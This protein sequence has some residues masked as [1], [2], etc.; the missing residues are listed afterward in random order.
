MLAQIL[1]RD[2]RKSPNLFSKQ[3]KE[4]TFANNR[5]CYSLLEDGKRKFQ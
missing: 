4:L 2:F 3:Y 1:V 5:Y